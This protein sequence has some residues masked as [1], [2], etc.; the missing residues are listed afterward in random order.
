MLNKTL[1]EGT[2]AELLADQFQT[3]YL[4]QTNEFLCSQNEAGIEIYPSQD[5]IFLA[6][7]STPFEEIRVVILGQDPYPTPGHAHGLAFSV[8][9]NITPLPKS[10]KNI[11]CELNDDLGFK[12][13]SGH[14]MPWAQ[15]G[16]FLLNSV[17]TVEK[18][19]PGSHANMGWELFTDHVIEI[20][21]S[22]KEKIV[23]VLWGNYAQ[24][25]GKKINREKHLV[26]ESAHPSPLSAYRGFFGSRPFTK[27]NS[28]LIA[29][30][31]E[32]IN[33][34]I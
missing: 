14:L 10:L 23:F 29:S 26:I 5:N 6:F 22:R 16:V 3:S 11:F 34:E 21:S 12:N 24:K 32:P 30:D 25:K 15:Q 1:L 13:V 8:K 7:N 19:K 4:R 28:F 18:G 9:P 20:I 17:L 33:W 31:K 2:W 27:I